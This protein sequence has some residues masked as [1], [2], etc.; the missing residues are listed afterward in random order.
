M[1]EK[2]FTMR[3]SADEAERL[4]ALARHYAITAAGVIR[5]LIKRDHDAL[6]G[7][8]GEPKREPKRRRA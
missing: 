6:P 7:N 1:R 4:A 8:A 5:M 3:I 2:L